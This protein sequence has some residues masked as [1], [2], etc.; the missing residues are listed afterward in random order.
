MTAKE[1]LNQIKSLK[2]SISYKRDEITQMYDEI[3]SVSGIDYSKDRVDTSTQA[4]AAFE[5]TANLIADRE[6]ELHELVE[7]MELT[8]IRIEKQ[9]EA[10]EDETYKMILRRRYV[11][12]WQL[13]DIAK[14]LNYSYDWI[15]HV[16]ADALKAFDE[17]YSTHYNTF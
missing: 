2:L 5:R 17:R 13:Y 16:H 10:M 1:Y 4:G 14:D 6:K 15:R 9:I 8:R 3:L 7:R 12:E 11:Q